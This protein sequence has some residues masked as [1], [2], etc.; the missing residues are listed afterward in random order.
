[1]KS[2]KAEVIANAQGM[3]STPSVVAFLDKE[4]LVGDVALA[5]AAKNTSNTIVECKSLLGRKPTD[6]SIAKDAK[7]WRFATVPKDGRAGVQVAYES[8]APSLIFLIRLAFHTRHTFDMKSMPELF[9]VEFKG[10]TAVFSAEYIAGQI[11]T[12]L[13]A[14][15][16]VELVC[17]AMKHTLLF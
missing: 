14:T 6:D 13:K 8:R 12:S 7:R 4:I 17:V 15:A 16:E 3:H 9:Q 10:Q 1:M 5:Q 2:D 11:F